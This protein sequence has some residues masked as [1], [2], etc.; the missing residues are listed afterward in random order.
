VYHASDR[1]D[2]PVQPYF[3]GTTDINYWQLPVLASRSVPG[4]GSDL[5]IAFYR[6]LLTAHLDVE[7]F[8]AN[9]AGSFAAHEHDLG[10]DSDKTARREYLKWVDVDGDGTLDLVAADKAGL[11]I[12]RGTASRDRP[13]EAAPAW[14]SGGAPPSDEVD[15]SVSEGGAISITFAG[16]ERELWRDLDGDRLA[17]AIFLN[18]KDI[19]KGEVS[20]RKLRPRAK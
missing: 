8:R 10:L 1:A 3:S 16:A 5:M 11:R 7:I 14:L 2:V 18:T 19:E 17:E 15:L 20:I 6:G 13:V 12:H 4:G 9:G